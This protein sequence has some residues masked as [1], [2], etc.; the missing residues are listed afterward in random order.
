MFFIIVSK[1]FNV[2]FF[3]DYINLLQLTFFYH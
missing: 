1:I 2:L 3:A